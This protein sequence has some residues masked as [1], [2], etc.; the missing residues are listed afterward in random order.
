[1]SQHDMVVDNG[2]GLTVRTDINAAL[3]ALATQSSGAT[4]P[5]ITFPCQVWAD[6]GTGRIKRRD[7]T[8]T[9]W[10][11][12]GPLNASLRQPASGYI[13]GL[14]PSWISATS[15]AV[16]PGAA[17]IPSTASNL[18]SASALVLTGLSLSATTWYYLYLYD[19]AGT[20]A[21]EL[22]TTAPDVA[23]AGTARTKTGDTSR[24]FICALRAQAANV[25]RSFIWA[26]D[27]VNYTDAALLYLALNTVTALGPVTFS[28]SAFIPPT[29]QR[30]LF[31]IYGPVAGGTASI[32][33]VSSNTLVSCAA[34][35]RFMGGSTTSSSQG[36][37]Y[38]HAATVTSGGTSLDIRGYGSER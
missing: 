31:Q 16:S 8:N 29:T 10:I 22:V 7:S 33:D 23:Y 21:I 9:S 17:Y 20:P 38:G 32:G 12:L 36:L 30:Y 28:A 37:W 2:A 18:V 13:D 26:D 19:N 24:R 14:I 35:N 3:G 27:Y 6:T 1:M 4:A 5:A 34:A 15:V 25:I 11:D